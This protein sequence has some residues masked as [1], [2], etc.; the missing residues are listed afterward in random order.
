M[1]HDPTPLG[2][3]RQAMSEARKHLEEVEEG[4]RQMDGDATHGSI[5]WGLVGS[6]N[7][8]RNDLKELA[9]RLLGRGEYAS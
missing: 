4:M 9:D 3:Y 8:L 7:Q 5:D 6:A 1:K 2:R